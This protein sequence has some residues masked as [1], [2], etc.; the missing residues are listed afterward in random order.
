MKIT[1]LEALI[2]EQEGLERLKRADIETLQLEKLNRL[3]RLEK[4]RQGF[5]KA[6]PERLN[7]LSE[8]AALPFTTAEDLSRHGGAM[9]L[10][11]QAEIQRVLT[12]ATSGT[13]GP[14][15]RLFYTR[16]DCENTVRLFM[17]GLSELIFPGGRTMICM[18]FSGPFGLGELIAEAVARLGAEPLKLGLGLSYGALGEIL[19]ERRPDTFV[20]MPVPLLSMLRALGP[21]SLRRALVSGDACPETVTRAAEMLL[22]ERLFPHY[23]SREMG[24]GGAV[25]C[26]AHQGMHLRENHVIAEIVDEAGRP[27]PPGMRGELVIS[28]IGME[29]MPLIRYRTGDFTS[30]L[31]GSCPCGSEIL[32]LDSVCRGGGSGRMRELDE[33]LFALERLVDY[34]AERDGSGLRIRAVVLPGAEPEIKERIAAAADTG[35]EKVTAEPLRPEMGLLYP[36][37]RSLIG[38]LDLS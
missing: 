4:E 15:K 32:R 2:K 36:G 12:E 8:L 17:A 34:R 16:G 31:P 13:T 26:Q 38:G 18:P 6:L 11:S 3:L 9:L 22:G 37:K 23:G 29:A 27:L 33:R 25:C 20:G 35:P 19:R 7:K 24:L 5:Y 30:V 14:A 21:G 28:T 1:G 10:R